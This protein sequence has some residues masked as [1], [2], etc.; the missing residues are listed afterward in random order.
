MRKPEFVEQVV[1]EAEDPTRNSLLVVDY[2]DERLISPFQHWL[3]DE[4][5]S[6]TASSINV[7]TEGDQ[8]MPP[9]SGYHC[10][11][12][13]NYTLDGIKAVMVFTMS[14]RTGGAL[15]S[16]GLLCQL[17]FVPLGFSAVHSASDVRYLCRL[18]RYS[19]HWAFRG[20]R[21]DSDLSVQQQFCDEV[22]IRTASEAVG[23]DLGLRGLE[24]LR[25][26]L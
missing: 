7:L 11:V 23:R 4:I 16:V 12:F 2:R 9:Y 24:G 5:M 15:C 6:N 26:G 13:A 17:G 14:S 8:L 19:I 20:Y 1:V 10:S 18:C 3:V 22:L 21:S 25:D